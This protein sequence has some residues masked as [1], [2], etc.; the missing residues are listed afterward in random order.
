MLN[1]P[2]LAQIKGRDPYLY[3]ALRRV[4]GAVNAIGRATGVDPAGS[5]SPPAPIGGLSVVAADGIFDVAITDH[6]PVHRGIF[7]FAESDSSADFTAPRVHFLGSSRNLRLALG[8]QTLYWRAYSQY[9]GSAP[10][11][12][13]SFGSPPAAVAGGGSA[14]PALQPSS[15][16]GS[17]TAQQG[18]SGFG[19]A[20][21]LTVNDTLVR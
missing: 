16:S 7:Y 17:A 12:P 9:I 18:G 14:G 8:N 6:S 20:P 21:T 1:I 11:A 15:G 2:Q 10:S 5:L 19:V 4:V 3:E 13:V